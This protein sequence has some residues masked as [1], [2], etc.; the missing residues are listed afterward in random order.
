MIAS[1]WHLKIAL[2][3][4][5][6]RQTFAAVRV[7]SPNTTYQVGSAL[8]LAVMTAIATSSGA[9]RPAASNESTRIEI[10]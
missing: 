1:V 7:I 4:W 5:L 10:R 6:T 3:L 8:G 9:D 2:V